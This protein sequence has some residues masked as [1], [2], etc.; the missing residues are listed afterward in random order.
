MS[1]SGWIYT[2]WIC[3]FVSFACMCSYLSVYVSFCV[4]LYVSLSV[5]FGLYL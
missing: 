2:G 5:C 4:C 1:A 3:M